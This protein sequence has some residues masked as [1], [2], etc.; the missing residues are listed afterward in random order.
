M[1]TT[2]L[3]GKPS[4][5]VVDKIQLNA[6]LSLNTNTCIKRM[7]RLYRQKVQIFQCS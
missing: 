5:K 1:N 7:V 6:S 2:I 3:H 4:T